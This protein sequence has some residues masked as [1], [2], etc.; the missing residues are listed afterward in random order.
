M[1]SGNGGLGYVNIR[2]IIDT[3][4]VAGLSSQGFIYSGGIRGSL[5]FGKSW[6][7]ELFSRFNAPSFSLQGYTANWFFHMIGI[8]KRFNKDK[9]G[10]GFGFDNPLA[11]QIDYKTENKGKDFTFNEV[12]RTNMWGFRVN[13]DYSFG[14]IESEKIKPVE[15]KLKN[16]DLKDGENQGGAQ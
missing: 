9:G 4:S 3:G 2:S 12:R 11:W 16:D 15:R 10:I 8:K 14:S 13:F 1:L 5:N 7:I 6:M